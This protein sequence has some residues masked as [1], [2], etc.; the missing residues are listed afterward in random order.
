MGFKKSLLLLLSLVAVIWF[1]ACSDGGSGGGG[2]GDIAGQLPDDVGISAADGTGELTMGGD[3]VAKVIP[4]TATFDDEVVQEFVELYMNAISHLATPPKG[5]RANTRAASS[6]LIYGANGAVRVGYESDGNLE[7]ERYAYESITNEF[8]D[9]SNTDSLYL[10]GSVGYLNTKVKNQN[11]GT[12]LVEQADGT[13]RFAGK[14]KGQIVFN[15]IVRSVTI[16]SDGKAGKASVVNKIILES[17]NAKIELPD[18][19]M[20]AFCYLPTKSEIEVITKDTATTFVAVTAINTNIAKEVRQ[21]DTLALLASVAPFEATNRKI[22]WTAENATIDSLGRVI[23]FSTA[24]TAKITATIKNGKSEKENFTQTWSVNVIASNTFVAVTGIQLDVKDGMSMKLNQKLSLDELELVYNLKV[25]PETATNKKI[26]WTAAGA[27]FDAAAGFT[28]NTVGNATIVATIT[29]GLSASASSDASGQSSDYVQTWRF[30]VSENGGETDKQSIENTA[31]VS[32]EADED[33]ASEF[34]FGANGRAA[35]KITEPSATGA[36]ITTTYDFTY[37]VSES[38][39]TIFGDSAKQTVAFRVNYTGSEQ[40]IIIGEL[41]FI[42][43]DK[44]GTNVDVGD[45]GGGKGNWYGTDCETITTSDGIVMEICD[46]DTTVISNG[47]FI[48]VQSITVNFLTTVNANTAYT[49]TKATVSPS[50][51]TNQTIVWAAENA[52]LRTNSTGGI[53]VLFNNPGD[54]ATITATITNGWLDNNGNQADFIQTWEMNTVLAGEFVAVTD[55]E[56]YLNYVTTMPRGDSL[57]VEK[58]VVVPSNAT[59]QTII[60]TVSGATLNGNWI[61]FNQI[62]SVRIKAEIMDGAY[63]NPEEG[64]SS[65]KSNYSKTWFIEVTD[66]GS[67]GG[68]VP[69][70]SVKLNIP[71][72]VAYGYEFNVTNSAT[73]FPQNA[74]NQTITWEAS[75]AA[76]YSAT[77]QKIVFDSYGQATITATI[78][79]GAYNYSS[80]GSII[81]QRNYAKTFFIT[82]SDGGTGDFV[83]VTNINIPDIPATIAPNSTFQLGGVVQPSDATRK[84]ITWTVDGA[85]YSNNLITFGDYDPN[86]PDNNLIIITA[87]IT[88][89][90]LDDNENASDYTQ[91]WFVE[92]T[93]SGK[94]LADGFVPVSSIYASFPDTVSLNS[95]LSLSGTVMPSNATKTSIEWSLIGDAILNKDSQIVTFTKTGIVAVN[96]G[97][98]AGSALYDDGS[99]ENYDQKWEIVVIE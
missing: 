57:S 68:F 27:T 37:A 25:L 55:I 11:G 47:G 52:T 19:L 22:V 10:G 5:L 54:I 53:E 97:I 28:F 72:T 41:A 21:G 50:N 6:S 33:G 46:G 70:D 90:T 23:K 87:K 15:N 86:D 9:F 92:I 85:T 39:V 89:G 13:I 69:V 14:F 61:I 62:G 42:K 98:I 1:F 65:G 71:S 30:V 2:G 18:S 7:T 78:A 40:K 17:G 94:V 91:Q 88:N 74:T 63:A 76:I 93:P 35:M 58:A 60:W 34:V 12:N 48:A 26:T 31:W 24:G 59:N 56:D 83:P 84:L 96:A 8:F 81:G 16:G 77:S 36:N 66:G 64:G 75:G 67:T 29:N 44:Y 51:A 20:S 99:Y 4:A 43:S 3:I 82:V 80:D 49:F 79:N 32:E 45:I 38:V 73:V 95:T